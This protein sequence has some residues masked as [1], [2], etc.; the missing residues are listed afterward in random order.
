MSVQRGLNE[1]MSEW[2]HLCLYNTL[3]STSLYIT[4]RCV[5]KQHTH[6]HTQSKHKLYMGKHK[7][8]SWQFAYGQLTNGHGYEHQ[9]FNVNVIFYI[10]LYMGKYFRYSVV[11]QLIWV[12]EKGILYVIWNVL[13]RFWYLFSCFDTVSSSQISKAYL[14]LIN[15]EN[16]SF[17]GA[18]HRRTD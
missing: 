14:T 15:A 5:A 1:W 12:H 9:D 16:L 2:V 6:T 13:F 3:R 11:S 4:A 8:T 18:S 10:D 17:V 7:H